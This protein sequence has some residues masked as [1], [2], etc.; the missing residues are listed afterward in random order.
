MNEQEFKQQ[1]FLHTD[2]QPSMLEQFFDYWSET[3]VKG[4]DKGKMKWQG[5]GSWDLNKRL[6]RWYNNQINWNHG[7]ANNTTGNKSSGTSEKRIE[8]L[9]QWGSGA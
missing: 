9:K 4:R 6:K 3:I 2:Y 7:Q 5:E 8:A 1:I